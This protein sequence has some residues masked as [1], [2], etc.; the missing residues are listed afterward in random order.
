MRIEHE[1]FLSLFLVS[2]CVWAVSTILGPVT[3]FLI[4]VL[5]C[6]TVAYFMAESLR[7]NIKD[8]A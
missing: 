8:E 3:V 1:I 5:L 6:L 2:V 7:E 4:I